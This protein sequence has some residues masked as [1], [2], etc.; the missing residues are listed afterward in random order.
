MFLITSTIPKLFPLQRQI[1]SEKETTMSVPTGDFVIS[2]SFAVLGNFK[3]VSVAQKWLV[4]FGMLKGISALL[5]ILSAPC[6]SLKSIIWSL[7]WIIWYL[8]S[9]AHPSVGNG[10]KPI[11][12]WVKKATEAYSEN[13][14]LDQSLFWD[15]GIFK[16]EGVFH[17]IEQSFC[18][19]LTYAVQDKTGGPVSSDFNGKWW[20]EDFPRCFWGRL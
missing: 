14:I 4:L 7:R 10:I 19:S 11:F 20:I 1:N 6:R 5:L 12:T 8:N 13:W 2:A 16:T 15:I 17:G 9:S 18:F 3:D